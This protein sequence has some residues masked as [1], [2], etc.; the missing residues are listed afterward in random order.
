[1]AKYNPN[2]SMLFWHMALVEGGGDWYQA[3]VIEN[4]QCAVQIDKETGAPFIWP[5]DV[6]MGLK[7]EMAR[8]GWRVVEDQ[9]SRH[10]AALG[11][12]N[13]HWTVRN[14]AWYVGKLI[15][16]SGKVRTIG[17]GS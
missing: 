5:V 3:F 14:L 10:F 15:P 8:D 12:T 11:D 6:A 1:M 9:D 16:D 2:R 13:R 17:S 7:A 4:N